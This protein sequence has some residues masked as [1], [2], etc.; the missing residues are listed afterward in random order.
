[1]KV[2][3]R[4]LDS[5]VRK[6]FTGLQ[7]HQYAALISLKYNC[8]SWYRNLV[9]NGITEVRFRWCNSAGGKVLRGLVTRRANERALYTKWVIY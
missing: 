5:K 7:D 8:H 2:I 9:R 6:D 3:V 4:Q 1:M